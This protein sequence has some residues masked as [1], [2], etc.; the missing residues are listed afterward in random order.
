M[1]DATLYEDTFSI[2]SIQ[3]GKYD[4]VYRIFGISSAAD[5]T[6]SLDINSELYPILVGESIQLQLASTLNL[7]GTKDDSGSG[8]RTAWR[9]NP[10]AIDGQQ[11]TTLADLFDYVCFGKVYQFKEAVGGGDTM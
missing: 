2:T 7:D 9:Y 4:R 10:S 6:L 3:S 5:T 11:E 8:N 1:A